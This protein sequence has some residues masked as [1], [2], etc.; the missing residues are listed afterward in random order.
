LPGAQLALARAVI[1]TAKP[2]VVVLVNGR[3]LS[4]PWLAEHAPAIVEAWFP[5]TEAGNAVADVLF[6][7]V[8]PGGK[9]PVTFPRTV[10]QT[11]IY[12][13]HKS[14]GRPSDATQKYTSRYLDVP[15]T[16]LFP[17]GYG[18][19]YTTFALT[20]LRISVPQVRPDGTLTVSADV[21]NTGTRRGDEVV[22]LYVQDVVASV[23]RPVQELKGFQRITLEPGARRRVEFT[24]GPSELGF[25]DV[26]MRWIVEP[27]QFR[28][29]VSNSS[30]GGLAGTFEVR[31]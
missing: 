27:G 31:P 20:D 18:L 10:G 12:Y 4:M 29:R 30:E 22:Q 26:H 1:G 7:R 11:P 19:S 8:N 16:P 5:G 3:P 23:T 24:L 17:F 2:V 14:T 6:G 9:L 15:F 13:D 28:V 21:T 25:Y